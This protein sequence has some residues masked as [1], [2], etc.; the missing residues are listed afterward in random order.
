MAVWDWLLVKTLLIWDRM[1]QQKKFIKSRFQKNEKKFKQM[2]TKI[3]QTGIGVIALSFLILLQACDS[4]PKQTTNTPN[5]TVVVS[6]AKAEKT[7]F[8]ARNLSFRELRKQ[9]AKP[10]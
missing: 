1:N 7:D 8:L 2:K 5:E 9:T 6:A 10:A 4:Q 3:L